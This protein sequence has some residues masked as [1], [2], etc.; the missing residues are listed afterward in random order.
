MKKFIVKEVFDKISENNTAGSKARIDIEYIA[1]KNG[2][3]EFPIY[4]KKM[5]NKK[6]TLFK[7]ITDHIYAYHVWKNSL[8]ELENAYLI[9][10]FPIV[11]GFIFLK[12]LLVWLKRKKVKTIAVIHDLET[13]RAAKVDN[14]SFKRRKRLYI[15]EI[16]PL[17]E[18]DYVVSHNSKMTK[19]LISCGIKRNRIIDLNIFD[20]IV[21]KPYSKICGEE[22]DTVVIAGNLS[23]QKA[24]YVYNLPFDVLFELYG[25]NYLEDSRENVHYNGI[26]S[27]DQIVEV[28]DGKFGLI[29]DG[30]RRDT[31]DGVFGRY[32][33]YNNP[34]KT[35]L[36]LAAGIPVIV[37]NQAAIKSF[38]VDNGLGVAIDSLDDLSEVMK[39]YTGEKYNKLRENVQ[40]ISNKLRTGHYFKEVL[41]QIQ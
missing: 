28:L 6:K 9:I 12:D 33:K 41:K 30:N 7:Q 34:H 32:L 22:K 27:A 23:K 35:S 3:Q 2:F 31:C 18:I 38:I 14:I 10:Q 36:Y 24:A 8:N 5:G 25:T 21:E 11:N 15:Q 20:Y 13:L 37:W 26:F 17:K 19:Y 29:W 1:Q 39:I 4:L 16:P 40:K